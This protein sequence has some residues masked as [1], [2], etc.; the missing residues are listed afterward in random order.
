[1]DLTP[2]PLAVVGLGNMGGGM[3]AQL[4]D[5]GFAVTVHNRTAAKA[6]PLVARGAVAADSP[7]QAVKGQRTVLLSLSDERAVDE[8]LFKRLVPVLE[9]GCLVIDTSTVS[10]G[11]AREAAVRLAGHGLPRV[12]ACVVGNPFQAAKGELRVYVS[13]EEADV[14]RARPVLDAI[15]S[16]VTYMGAPGAATTIKLIF[17]TLLGVQ[18]ASMAEAVTY[19]VEAGLDRDLLLTAIASSG[20]SSVVMRF[21]AELMR[22]S[23]YEPAFFRTV[24]MEKDLRLAVRSAREAGV[25]LPVL[26]RAR[27]RFEAVILAGEGDKDAAVI[28]EHPAGPAGGTR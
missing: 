24:L 13:G 8:V 22:R 17:N 10:P 1:M 28:I 14:D 12:E 5:S 20:F 25:E 4:L 21:R 26:E 16:E 9:P 6:E 15:G 23:S 11:Y 19:G 27:E 18:V 2:A 3:A 7:E